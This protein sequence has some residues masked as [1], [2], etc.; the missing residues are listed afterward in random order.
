VLQLRGRS[1]PGFAL[2]ASTFV[3][4][5]TDLQ[6][7]VTLAVAAGDAY[8]LSDAT[9]FR[10]DFS[11]ATQA[12]Q[13]A[14]QAGASSVG[15]EIDGAGASSTTSPL[16]QQ[17]WALN[18]QLA[19]L[20]P[21][22]Q[23]DPT[24]GVNAPYFNHADADRARG[25]VVS[26]IA[27]YTQAIA[28]GAAASGQPVPPPPGPQPSPSPPSPSPSPAPASS[29]GASSPWLWLAPLVVAGGIFTAVVLQKGPRH[30]HA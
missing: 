5:A 2:G 15:P 20:Q 7:Q 29:S 19:A 24:N 25:L 17:A 16:T 18:G 28:A 3:Q 8:Y 6:N 22:G 9:G 1:V 10:L 27:L 30:A 21:S 14:G 26:M 13:A 4:A 12:Y 11:D 23:P